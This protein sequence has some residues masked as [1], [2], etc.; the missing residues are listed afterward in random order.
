MHDTRQVR[1]DRVQVDRVLQPGRER[2]HGAVGVV[3]GRLNRRSTTCCTRRRSGLN[4][5]AAISV[6]AATSTGE[7]NDAAPARATTAA[8]TPTS[9]PVTIA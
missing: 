2:G 6:A 9:S 3:P 8:Y 5:A 7:E 1:T 4:R